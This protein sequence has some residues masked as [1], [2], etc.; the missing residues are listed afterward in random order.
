MCIRDSAHAA[1]PLIFPDARAATPLIFPDARAA[2]PLIFL[3]ARAI[4]RSFMHTVATHTRTLHT[5]GR[6]APELGA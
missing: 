1:T 5:H 2:T 6:V 4:L 3:D